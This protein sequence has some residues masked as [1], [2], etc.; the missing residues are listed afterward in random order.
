LGSSALLGGAA[1]VA[2]I[3][4]AQ[5]GVVLGELEPHTTIV[6]DLGMVDLEPV[7]LVMAFEEEFGVSI[8]DEDSE[9]LDSISRLVHYFHQRVVRSG[10]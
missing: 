3:T 7:E 1:I 4:C 2:E 10:K 8:S 5:L 6:G 9:R